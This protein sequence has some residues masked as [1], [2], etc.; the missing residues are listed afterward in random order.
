MINPVLYQ[1]IKIIAKLLG[2]KSRDEFVENIDSITKGIEQFDG[3][4]KRD[5]YFSRKEM[6]DWRREYKKYQKHVKNWFGR[7]KK[8]P[9]LEEKAETFNSYCEN[10]IAYRKKHNEIYIQ[11]SLKK[12]KKYFDTI[13]T[14]PLT[15]QQR[16]AVITDEHNNYVNAGAGCGKT[17]TIIAKIAFLV[18]KKKVD[19]EKILVLVFND[20][21]SKV[22]I[23]RL[24]KINITEVNIKTFHSYGNQIIRQTSEKAPE[25]LF[26]YDREK[27]EF[28]Q[29]LFSAC[30]RQNSQYLQNVVFYFSF[31][32]EENK[33]PQEFENINEYL[34]YNRSGNLRTFDGNYVRSQQELKIANYLCLNSINYEYEKPYE[35]DTATKTHSQYRPDFYLTDYGI[36][37][38]HFAMNLDADNGYVS[39]FDGYLD[40][41]YWKTRQHKKNGTKL[42][43]TF[44]YQFKDGTVFSELKKNLKL[45]NVVFKKQSDK[46]ILKMI[47]KNNDKVIYKFTDLLLNFMSLLKSSRKSLNSLKETYKDDARNIAF[48]KI[49]EPI[50]SIY[51]DHLKKEKAIDFDDMI[52]NSTDALRKNEFISDFDYVII[53]EFQDISF[54]RF[55]MVDRIRN[56][57]PNSKL[58]CVGDDW[59]AIYRFAGGDVSILYNFNDYFGRYTKKLR[60]TKTFRLPKKVASLSDQFIKTNPSQSQKTIKTTKDIPGA[61]VFR[62]ISSDKKQI[63]FLSIIEQ[64]NHFAKKN[65]SYANILILNRYS[66]QRVVR[67]YDEIINQCKKYKNVDVQYSTIHRMKGGEADYVIVD[68]VNE[69]FVGFPNKMGEDSVLKMLLQNEENF[70]DAEERRLFYVAITRCKKQVFIL[71]TVGESS[72]F[73]TELHHKVIDRLPCKE[74]GGYMIRR[75]N[76]QKQKPFFGCKNFPSCK[77]TMRVNSSNESYL[78]DPIQTSVKLIDQV[79]W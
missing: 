51:Q 62:T 54:G 67:D 15:K 24:K 53:D 76:Q 49:F 70:M 43:S 61:V 31:Y 5:N 39:I 64:I 74:C 6:W 47:K 10:F 28:I 71:S 78:D 42:V 59:Q 36:Y 25:I 68:D 66:F 55:S 1:I 8:I 69:G 44:S 57:N 17:E 34:E 40:Q 72:A 45:H 9:G 33:D 65:D 16:L 56:Q 19:P 48:I 46:E 50:F 37:L 29:D 13:R 23:E 12:Y 41:H 52:T 2:Y 3:Y 26:T 63:Q 21:A 79:I 22:V 77:N 4:L 73:F 60:L 32:L 27:K 38:E 14:H 75:M 58:F 11:N 30:M 20:L 35:F 18:Q 7:V